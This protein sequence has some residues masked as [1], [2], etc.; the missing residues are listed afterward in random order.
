M[1]V[2]DYPNDSPL[3][4]YPFLDSEMS[5][6]SKGSFIL[7]VSPLSFTIYCMHHNSISKEKRIT[8]VGVLIAG[9]VNLLIQFVVVHSWS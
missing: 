2:Q 6:V 3:D 1:G 5:S 4:T 7:V 8:E 9:F